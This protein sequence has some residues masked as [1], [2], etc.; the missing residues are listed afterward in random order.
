MVSVEARPATMP[1]AVSVDGIDLILRGK[2]V[3]FLEARM[4]FDL[5]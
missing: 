2:R 1:S 3:E 4:E 5:L